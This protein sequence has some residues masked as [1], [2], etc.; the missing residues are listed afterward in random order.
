M[1]SVN[2]FNSKTDDAK[3]NGDIIK[4]PKVNFLKTP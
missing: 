1:I 4:S 2:F 3:N